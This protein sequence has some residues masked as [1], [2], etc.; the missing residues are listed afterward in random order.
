MKC[1]NR[2]ELEIINKF[3]L[4]WEQHIVWTRMAITSIVFDTPDQE[5]VIARLLR[6]PTDLSNALK[7]FYKN[8]HNNNN[9]NNY[10]NND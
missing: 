8:T 5:Q 3:R 10:Y 6:N 9:N 2:T 4:L 1:I 7:I